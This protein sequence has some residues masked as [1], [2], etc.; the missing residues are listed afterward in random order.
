[1][2]SEKIVPWALATEGIKLGSPQGLGFG[3]EDLRKIRPWK[4]AN[5]ELAYRC[6]RPAILGH[7]GGKKPKKGK[8]ERS[9]CGPVHGS[10]ESHC[11]LSAIKGGT[12]RGE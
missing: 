3:P 4:F 1:M 12:I 10:I 11:R 8:R 5:A 7:I 9:R 6:R 2:R